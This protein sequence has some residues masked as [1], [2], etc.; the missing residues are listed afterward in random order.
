MLK[1]WHATDIKWPVR[2]RRRSLIYLPSTPENLLGA[3]RV[4]TPDIVALPDTKHQLTNDIK[5]CTAL[6]PCW[7]GCLPYEPRLLDIAYEVCVT[8]PVGTKDI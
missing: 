1:E 6:V 8:G 4:T 3:Y 2:G 5:D 7:I